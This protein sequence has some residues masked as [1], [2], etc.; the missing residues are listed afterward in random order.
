MLTQYLNELR[1][2]AHS[3]DAT[4]E[5][6]LLFA[7]VKAYCKGEAALEKYRD[8]LVVKEINAVYDTNAQL[9]FLFN[10][11]L[12]P[13]EYAAYQA[14]RVECKAKA[15]ATMARLKAELEKAV[16]LS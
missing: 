16:L 15:D 7:Y 8:R 12:K 14:F 13:D 5:D 4:S 9:A 2:K 6:R 11:V 3:I 10:Q 1:K